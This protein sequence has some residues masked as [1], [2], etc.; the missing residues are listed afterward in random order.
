MLNYLCRYGSRFSNASLWNSSS[1]ETNRSL[2]D[3]TCLI[4]G[5]SVSNNIHGS[6]YWTNNRS[7][8]NTYS[9]SVSNHLPKL[10]HNHQERTN[11]ATFNSIQGHSRTFEKFETG[12]EERTNHVYCNK[13]TGKRNASTSLDLDLSLK[14]RVP[15]E[16]T[17]E[18]TETATTTDQTLSLSLCSWKK[19]RVIKTDEED[20]TV[21]I[22]QASTLDL[23]LWIIGKNETNSKWDPEVLIQ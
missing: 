19:S 4:R 8:P 1:H 21:K 18:E 14:V 16:T 6:E 17:L 12:I 13:T 5:S 15:E 20:R 2:I 7:F 23:T 10:R 9:S 22:G 3:R 11:L